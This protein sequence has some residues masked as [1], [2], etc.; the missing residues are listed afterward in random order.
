MEDSVKEVAP[1]LFIDGRFRPACGAEPVIEAATGQVFAIGP[2]AGVGEVD[3]ATAA[4]RRALPEWKAMSAADRAQFLTRLAGALD[5]RAQETA[6]LCT[7]EIGAPITYSRM[8]NGGTP[9]LLL[10]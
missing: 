10:R 5:A 8:M 6:T 1:E 2:R 3:D 4:A 7:R 9:G